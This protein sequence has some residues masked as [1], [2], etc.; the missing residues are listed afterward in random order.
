MEPDFSKYSIVELREALNS[1][2]KKKYPERVVL[3]N[4]RLNKLESDM[5]TLKSQNSQNSS[6]KQPIM[7]GRI[8]YL[9]LSLLFIYFFVSTIDKGQVSLRFGSTLSISESPILFYSVTII[10]LVFALI[11]GM[12]SLY[13]WVKK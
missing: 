3:I 13:Y 10:L 12:S 6:V 11:F 4:D 2:D 7:F 8:G 9:F 5:K 1:I